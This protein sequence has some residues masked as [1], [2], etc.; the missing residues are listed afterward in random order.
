MPEE[1]SSYYNIGLTIVVGTILWFSGAAG[2]V[3]AFFT[4]NLSTAFWIAVLSVVL[5]IIFRGK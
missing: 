5:F 2:A 3:L 4:S 1:K